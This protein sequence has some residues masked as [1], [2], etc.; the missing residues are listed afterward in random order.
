M[1]KDK[2]ALEL[3][4]C[5]YNLQQQSHDNVNIQNVLKIIPFFETNKLAFFP[6]QKLS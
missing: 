6:K 1:L 3:A 2:N 4:S 5:I